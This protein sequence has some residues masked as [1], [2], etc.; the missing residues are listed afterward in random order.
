MS[1]DRVKE[2]HEQLTAGVESIFNDKDY[3]E[4]LKAM[5]MFHNYSFG[6]VALILAQKP[7]ATRVAGFSAWKK[8][9]RYPEKG[10]AIYILAPMHY[11]GGE[12]TDPETK[13]RVLGKDGQPIIDKPY[14]RF[15]ATTVFD[16][17][18]TQGEPLP[19]FGIDE[20][21]GGVKDYTEILNAISDATPYPI[22]FEDISNGADG[23]FHLREKRI[24][25]NNGMSEK[26][27]IAVAIHEVTHADLHDIDLD[28]PRKEDVSKRKTKNAREVEADS[29]AYVICNYY[30]IDTG[31]YNFAYIAAWSSGKD[32]KELKASLDIIQKSSQDLI[33]RIDTQLIARL[34]EK[35]KTME[36]EHP[37]P[38]STKNGL[39]ER[40]DNACKIA[41][42]ANPDKIAGQAAYRVC[43]KRLDRI[44]ADFPGQIDGVSSD[45]LSNFKLMLTKAAKSPDLEA[46]KENMKGIKTEYIWPLTQQ[47][48][49][50]GD[51]KSTRGQ[52]RNN[53]PQAER[54]R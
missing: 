23:Y 15:K 31:K 41:H 34:T 46:L 33:D 17:S 8:L 36:P 13:K 10:T 35:F 49:H 25:I 40:V 3:Q 27:N 30:G 32:L 44:V 22:V 6:N 38:I 9:K 12:R 2:L 53:R 50:G 19:E 29:V 26:A 14:T 37:E 16:V 1:D 21:S 4:Y 51:T 45:V 5:S 11:P 42:A 28:N 20:L 54:N 39:V 47:E 7:D 24:A 43:L 48:R 18:D 52:R